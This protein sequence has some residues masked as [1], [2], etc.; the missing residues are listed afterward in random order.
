MAA[1]WVAA[2]YNWAGLGACTV[3]DVA[4]SLGACSVPIAQ[5]N[6][7]AQI[8]VQDLPGTIARANDPATN[9][10]IPESLRSRFTFMAHDFYSPT[11]P[12]NADVFFVR[13][14]MHDYSDAYCVK[15]LR[16][17]VA[18]LK[19]GGRIV[20]MDQVLPPVGGAPYPLE[21]FMRA[22][23]MQMGLLTNAKERDREQWEELLGKT[24]QRLRISS[25]ATPPG[26]VMALIEVV[27]VEEGTGNGHAR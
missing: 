22:Q 11:Q 9:T 20:I 26:S 5:A 27:L 19:P 7:S 13:M 3:V 16:P 12:I 24:D 23:D 25:V 10:V 6:P 17:L 2:G 4:G 21:R 14:I 18:A 8:I 1:S 15:I